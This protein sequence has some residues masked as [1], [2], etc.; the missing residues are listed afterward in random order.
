MANGRFRMIPS[1]PQLPSLLALF[2]PP[3]NCLDIYFQAQKAYNVFED[4]YLTKDSPFAVTKVNVKGGHLRTAANSTMA[5]GFG[6]K[7]PNDIH[8]H[9]K[10]K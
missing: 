9:P 8:S 5:F 4:D 3:P 1:L 2:F 10:R 7:N 6:R